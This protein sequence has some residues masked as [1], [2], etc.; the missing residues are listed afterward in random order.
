MNCFPKK[1]LLQLNLLF[2]RV[3]VVM[4]AQ[5][6]FSSMAAVVMKHL[7]PRGCRGSVSFRVHSDCVHPEH[8]S[9][10]RGSE[11]RHSSSSSVI[12]TTAPCAILHI[13]VTVVCDKQNEHLYS[14]IH[15]IC[16]GGMWRENP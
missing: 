3:S 11:D 5:L 7:V 8:C 10:Q 16:Q 9:C 1:H 13:M 14:F 4:G 6:A 15:S 2:D 12:L